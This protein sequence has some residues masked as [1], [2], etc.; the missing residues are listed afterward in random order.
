[1][2]V[3]LITVVCHCRNST[4]GES[5]PYVPSLVLCPIVVQVLADTQYVRFLVVGTLVFNTKG[6]HTHTLPLVS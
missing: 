1:M 4:Y 5:V 2:G 6:G 3:I